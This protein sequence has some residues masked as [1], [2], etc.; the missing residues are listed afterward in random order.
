M[1]THQNGA[2]RRPVRA[3]AAGRFIALAAAATLLFAGVSA[4]SQTFMGQAGDLAAQA[5]FSTSGNQLLIHLQNTAA[6]G[7]NVNADVLTGLFFE[8]SGVAPLTAGTIALDGSSFYVN[9][10]GS[11]LPSH[12]AFRPDIAEQGLPGYGLACAGYG[13]FGAQNAFGPAQGN[14]IDGL[15]YGLVSSLGPDATGGLGNNGPHIQNGV[16]IVLNGWL[17]GLTINSVR[18]Q[19]GTSLN[20]PWITVD[21]NGGSNHGGEVPEPGLLALFGAGSVGSVLTA[22]RARRRRHA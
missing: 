9:G 15:D 17:E 6:E 18:F 12:W 3:S 11:N 21:R 19:Y 7:A 10:T 13:V 4:Q 5:T 22:V 16:N 14:D 8:L 1:R 20:E 2:M